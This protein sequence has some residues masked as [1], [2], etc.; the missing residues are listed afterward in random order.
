MMMMIL[1]L[2]LVEFNQYIIWGYRVTRAFL[3]GNKN[4]VFHVA[5]LTSDALTTGHTHTYTLR[6][7]LPRAFI[8]ILSPFHIYLFVHLF[9]NS[10]TQDLF[11]KRVSGSDYNNRI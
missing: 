1:V 7:Q 3:C 2:S 9:I 4:F 8:C 5:R 6:Q 10:F 11:H